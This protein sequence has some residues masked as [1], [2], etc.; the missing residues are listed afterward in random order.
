MNQVSTRTEEISLHEPGGIVR[1]VVKKD[2][3][4]TL[5]DAR[6]NIEAVKQLA[7]GRLVPVLVDIRSSKGADKGARDFFSGKEATET[8]S[9][10]AL[11]VGSLV[12]Q[13][14]GNFFLGLN[15]TKF[16]IQ[17]FTSEQKAEEWL[18]TF[19]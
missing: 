12:S 8:Q 7:N 5:D 1:C 4:M 2:A 14:I 16:P 19:L 13:L 15:K 9:A 11:L 3:F 6:E 10:C 17:V 18:K